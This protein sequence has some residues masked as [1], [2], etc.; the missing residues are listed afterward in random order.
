MYYVY[1]LYNTEHRKAD[2]G[3]TSDLASRIVSYNSKAQSCEQGYRR[4]I[5]LHVEKYLTKKSA[6]LR[7]KEL[8]SGKGRELI[9]CFI[10]QKYG[11]QT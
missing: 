9:R 11:C 3:Y 4:W 1:I 7:E 5:L 8:K 6:V 10:N 2:V